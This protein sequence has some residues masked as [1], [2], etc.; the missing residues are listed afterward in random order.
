MRGRMRDGAAVE[1]GFAE[2]YALAPDGS[3]R[4]RRSYFFTAAV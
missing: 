1:V 2:V 4:H 3:I